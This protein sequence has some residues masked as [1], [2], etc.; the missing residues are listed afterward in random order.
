MKTWTAWVV[1]PIV[2]IGSVSVAAEQAKSPATLARSGLTIT[3]ASRSSPPKAG[4]NQFD[5]T[6][7]GAD[8]KPVA[9]A[10]VAVSFVMPAMPA[11]NM[12]EMRSD[13]KL[14]PAGAGKYAGS[15]QVPMAGTWN[16]T[17]TVKQGGKE[18]GQ[19]TL[20]LTAK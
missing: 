19:K 5:V 17:V 6:L 12:A 16:V 4:E 10:D 11:M 20:K 13:V 7:K 9:D 18:L 8:G 14:K 1:V 15:G 2:A 3:F